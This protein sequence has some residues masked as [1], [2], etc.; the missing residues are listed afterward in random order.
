MICNAQRKID[1]ELI[2]ETRLFSLRRKDALKKAD[3][4][5]VVSALRLPLDN[6]LFVNFKHHVVEVD[7]VDD[8]NVIEHFTDSNAFIQEGIDSGGGV[9]VHWWVP[10]L[11][12][13]FL[14]KFGLSLREKKILP[15]PCH[16]YFAV[17]SILIRWFSG[18][19]DASH[20]AQSHLRL[21]H[22]S[23]STS[24]HITSLS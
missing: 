13:V 8:E 11:S 23:T 18:F 4:T 10:R 16:H 7:D 19:P 17:P 6:E 1:P 21:P 22:T 15:Y 5:H 24:H 9:L 20:M 2:T 12:L 3:I 14:C